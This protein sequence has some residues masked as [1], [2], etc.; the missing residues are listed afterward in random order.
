MLP[1][2][3]GRPLF[4]EKVLVLVPDWSIFMLMKNS[5]LHSLIGWNNTSRLV[6]QSCSHWSVKMQ[7][8]F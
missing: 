5:S 3:K 1:Q 2:T 6:L 7:M 8:Q 4:I